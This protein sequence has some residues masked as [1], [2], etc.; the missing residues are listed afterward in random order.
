MISYSTQRLDGGFKGDMNKHSFAL[1]TIAAKSNISLPEP[2]EQKM[3]EESYA[4]QFNMEGRVVFFVDET[5]AT[6]NISMATQFTDWGLADETLQ[7]LLSRGYA[8][9]IKPLDATIYA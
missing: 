5:N 1:R 4:L 6:D 9:S 7:W 2:E 8:A 3:Y